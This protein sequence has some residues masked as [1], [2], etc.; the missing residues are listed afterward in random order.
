[1]D[2]RLDRSIKRWT[3]L[4]LEP[5]MDRPYGFILDR[6]RFPDRQFGPSGSLRRYMDGLGW[7]AYATVKG[8]PQRLL[9][10]G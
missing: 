1:M 4:T 7:E 3:G 2:Y 5:T 10:S 6:F 8:H 9:E